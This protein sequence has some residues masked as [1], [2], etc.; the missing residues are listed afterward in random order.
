MTTLIMLQ[1]GLLIIVSSCFSIDTL[2]N[3]ELNDF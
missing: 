3:V 1:L 2:S